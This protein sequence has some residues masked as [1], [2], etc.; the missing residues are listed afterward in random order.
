[1]TST[2]YRLYRW[3]RLELTVFLLASLF[4]CA[5]PPPLP[6]EER[7]A[8]IPSR[9]AQTEAGGFYYQPA[10]LADDFPEESTTVS[11]IRHDL[12]TVRATGAR[13]FRFG[14]GW[15]GIETAPGKYE[16]GFWDELVRLA[17]EYGVT[18][19]PYVCYTPGWAASDPDPQRSWRSP[20]K[21]LSAFGKFMGVIAARYRGKIPSWEL[22]NEPD[23][24]NYWTG[25]P[26]QFAEMIRE[27][28]RQVRQADPQ[29]MI[30]L[31]GMAEGKS[32]FLEELLRKH[33]IGKEVDV[34][35]VHGYLE[36][37]S[38]ETAEEYPHRLQEVRDLMEETAPDLDLWLAEFGY[39]DYRMTKSKVSDWVETTFDYEHTPLYQGVSLWKHH[40]LAAASEDVSLTTWYRI[41]DLP[42]SEGVIG[43]DNNR[44]L[45]IVD[46]QGRPKPAW[47]ALRL[48]NA[49]FNHPFRVA[50]A[51]VQRAPGSQS[52]IH[53]FE[54]SDGNWIVTAWLRSP[55]KGEIAARS[56]VAVDRRAETISVKLPLKSRSVW[57]SYRIDGKGEMTG[58][59]P[60]GGSLE[61]IRLTGGSVYIVEVDPE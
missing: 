42:P 51:S 37:W 10:G 30:V 17:P 45:G 52:E 39:S 8:A 54:E 41:H 60:P 32:P 33:G 43:D 25:T 56:G 57:K 44:F 5:A 61:G 28:A 49:I 47:Q 53:I 35:N 27:G 16:W 1:M 22:W 11:K 2:R 24:E 7:V 50:R 29:A 15:D 23:I 38:P 31:G 20:P 55:R 26:G 18:L 36:T 46:L 4:G 34:V 19:L 14:I 58:I 12:E 21:D 13:Y 59:L 9:S 40:V 48:Y 6:E 3:R